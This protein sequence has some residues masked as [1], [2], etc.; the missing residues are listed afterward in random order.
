MTYEENN[1]PTATFIDAKGN[2]EQISLVIDHRMCF[3]T[4]LRVIAIAPTLFVVYDMPIYNGQNIHEITTF[5]QRHEKIN[6]IIDNFHSPDLCALIKVEDVPV[7][8]LKR[9]V[10]SYDDKPGS[11]GVFSP[12]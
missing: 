10:E 6:T 3:G 8:T 12:S 5:G 4:K 9:G 2:E 7:N 1:V 11:I